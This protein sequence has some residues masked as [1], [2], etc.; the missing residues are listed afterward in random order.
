MEWFR[1]FTHLKKACVCFILWTTGKPEEY[2]MAVT[3]SDTRLHMHACLHVLAG[4]SDDATNSS[5]V[6]F[7]RLDATFGCELAEKEHLSVAQVVVGTRL[8]RRYR[9]Q[10]EALGMTVLDEEAIIS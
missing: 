9:R 3:M 1:F 8:L 10:L 4:R 7:N 2:W 5:H 6:G